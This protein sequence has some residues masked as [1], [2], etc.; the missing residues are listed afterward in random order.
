[1]QGSHGMCLQALQE[2][3]CFKGKAR[4]LSM[5]ANLMMASLT[6]TQSVSCRHGCRKT[7]TTIVWGNVPEEC[8]QT[9]GMCLL[10]LTASLCLPCYRQSP[11]GSHTLAASCRSPY[12]HVE[13]NYIAVSHICLFFIT[14][15]SMFNPQLNFCIIGWFINSLTLQ[16]KVVSLLAQIGCSACSTQVG[17]THWWWLVRSPRHCK[18][19][20][21]PEKK[22]YI[23]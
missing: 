8:R 19:F 21:F 17:A 12:L 4:P 5:A 1:M 2:S 15:N 10:N 23:Q 7:Y 6:T 13:R 16:L 20:E 9:F 22:S 14:K 11:S 18:H 3:G